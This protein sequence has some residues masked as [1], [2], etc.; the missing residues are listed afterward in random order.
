[1]HFEIIYPNETVIESKA[2]EQPKGSCNK[3]KMRDSNG[4]F[5][6]GDSRPIFLCSGCESLIPAFCKTMDQLME[7]VQS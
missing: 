5:G 7:W 4:M 6:E 1:M 2:F 3:C